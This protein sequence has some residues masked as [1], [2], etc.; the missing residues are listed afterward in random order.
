MLVKAY[1]KV[2]LSL[3]IIGKREDNYH[4]LR[5]IIQAIDLYDVIIIN[6]VSKGIYLYCDKNYIPCDI[7]NL[8]YKAADLFINTYNISGGIRINIKKNIPVSAGLAGGSADAAAV[9]RAMR[10]IYKPHLS[11]KELEKL[12][13]KIGT[14]VVY[15]INGGTALCEG[16]GEKVTRITSFKNHILVLVKPPF[17]VS[18]KEA[19][20]NL[21]INKINK[22][23]D[24][25][26]ILKAIDEDNILILSKNMKNILENVVLKKHFILKQI[27]RE[28]MILGAVGCLM[29]GSGPTIFG[30]FDDMLKAQNCYDKMKDK[31]KEV[32]ITR[33]I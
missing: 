25:K 12:A 9:L 15:C 28:T 8:A 26:L 16:I 1:A 14:D 30:L 13:L 7:R 6:K 29:S 10:D 11:N 17:G 20:S 4:I 19:Y 27:K 32:F 5:T 24:T 33:T 21:D 22:H 23:P 18:S 31:Y 3:D 2:N